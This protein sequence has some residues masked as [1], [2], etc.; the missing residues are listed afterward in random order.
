MIFVRRLVPL[1]LR[2]WLGVALLGVLLAYSL[3]YLE[4]DSLRRLDAFLY[5]ARVRLFANQSVD[6][7]IAIVDID[8]RSLAELGRW[9]WNRARLAEL[10]ERIFGEYGALLLGLDVILAEA[11]E[12][13]GL[14]SLDALERGPLHQNTAFRAALDDLRPRLD[15]DGRLARVLQRY[16]VILGF[17]L[18]SGAGAARSGALPPP[19]LPAAGELAGQFS[20][21]SGYGGNLPILQQAAIGAGFLGAP[22]DPDGVTRRAWLLA[23]HDGQ[24]YAA[25]SL[26]MAQVLLGNPALQI[27]FAER[28]S[29]PSAA[30]GVEAI[31][32][33]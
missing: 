17:H 2:Q 9:P 8:E 32:L 4:I 29:W 31:D 18:S 5:D 27:R 13:S 15:Y 3:R 20:Q 7:R 25:L 14:A 23:T 28:V 22:V 10:I 24:V 33:F 12:S 26:V 1:D 11:D 19:V 6:E 16:P 21:W 30:A